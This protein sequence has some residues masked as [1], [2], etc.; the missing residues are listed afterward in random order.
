M[1]NERINHEPGCIPISVRV[2]PSGSIQF[3][4]MRVN[5]GGREYFI[6]VATP[7]YIAELR[8][9]NVQFPPELQIDDRALTLD[10]VGS[11]EHVCRQIRATPFE[12]LKDLLTPINP[13][14]DLSG[15]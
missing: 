8:K 12:Q 11:V 6:N 14:A 5:L 10:S 4:E 1:T 2:A 9:Y 13:E 3:R 7:D 15:N